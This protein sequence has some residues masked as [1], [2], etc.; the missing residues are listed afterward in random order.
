VTRGMLV[1]AWVVWWVVG[2]A[3]WLLLED[4]ATIAE[5]VD[6]AVAAALGASA[7]VLALS[8]ARPRPGRYR[9][10]SGLWRP[11]V[12][13]MSDLPQLVAVLGRAILRGERDP[14]R[15]RTVSFSCET[16]PERRAAQIALA[17]FAGSVAPS[18]VVIAVRP[19]EDTLLFHELVPREGR[20]AADPLELG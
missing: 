15:V 2:M 11:L 14:G 19:A 4:L 17:S 10:W 20:R 3:L 16:D 7:A 1:R 18:T 8:R 13:L 9:G 12:L 5:D 6:G